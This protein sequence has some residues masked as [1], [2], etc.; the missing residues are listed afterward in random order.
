MIMLRFSLAGAL[1]CLAIA[2]QGQQ[3]RL[4]YWGETLT[5]YGLRT[6]VEFTLRQTEK[7]QKQGG[8]A[9][10]RLLG[11]ANL[12]IYRHPDNHI[13]AILAPELGWRRTGKS[14]S[15]L[16]AAVSAGVFRSFY[17]ADTWELHT[18]G[19]FEKVPLAGQWGFLPGLSLGMGHDFSIKGKAPFLLF[20]NIHYMQQHP[21]NTSFLHKAAIEVGVVFKKS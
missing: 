19:S 2:M 16:Q 11:S 13:G 5:H 21:Y 1:F 18:N 10:Q 6:G 17:E 3:L 7:A 15:V 20:A 14:G 12:S 8:T 9:T 4:A